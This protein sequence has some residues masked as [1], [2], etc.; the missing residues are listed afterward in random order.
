[1]SILGSKGSS[2]KPTPSAPIIGTATKG[3]ASASVTFTAPFSKLPIT[4]YTV[5]S[6]PGGFTGTGSSSPIVVSGLT[7]GTAYTFTVTATNANGT[8]S[9]SAA[10]NSVTPSAPTYSLLQTFNSSG[11]F[12]NN[13][14]VSLLAVYVIGAGGAGEQ[15]N[16]G[17]VDFCA[18][19]NQ[20]QRSGGSGGRGGMGGSGVLAWD[21]STNSGQNFTVT[22]GSGGTNHISPGGSTSFGNFAQ[23]NT[24]GFGTTNSNNSPF[25]TAN[26]GNNANGG[27]PQSI[28]SSG[29]TQQGNNGQTGNPGGTLTPNSGA[30]L[31]SQQVGGSGGGG[32]GGASTDN[33]SANSPGNGGSVGGA[34]GGNAGGAGANGSAN[35]GG[36]GGGGGNWTGNVNGNG[37]A[38]GNRGSGG[39]GRILVYGA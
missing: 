36:G 24:F 22:I 7:N 4:G 19:G 23:A 3:N 1:M 33:G 17:Y 28:N 37:N 13:Y 15:G 10:S 39:N 8:S 14:G 2:A 5:T 32:A 21:V 34:S 20:V 31:V 9:A 38:G 18:T 16:T 6:S 30:G 35:G 29:N 26:G 25:V 11:T 12:T 27:N